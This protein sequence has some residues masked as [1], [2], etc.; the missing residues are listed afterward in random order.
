MNLRNGAKAA[1]RGFFC[2]DPKAPQSSRRP[3]NPRLRSRKRNRLTDDP[4][5]LRQRIRMMVGLPNTINTRELHL[6][7]RHITPAIREYVRQNEEIICHPTM[8]LLPLLRNYAEVKRKLKRIIAK[9][10]QGS[11]RRVRLETIEKR[12]E[13]CGAGSVCGMGFC[14]ICVTEHKLKQLDMIANAVPEDGPRPEFRSVTLL[15]QVMYGSLEEVET[16]V[17]AFKTRVRAHF[18]QGLRSHPEIYKGVRLVLAVEV[19]IVPP[20]HQ[21]MRTVYDPQR[22]YRG[23][24]ES[25]GLIGPQKKRCLVE[26][27]Y[28]PAEERPGWF[29]T[30]HGLL[31][32]ETD[33]KIE[34][35]RSRMTTLNVV[36]GN[37]LFPRHRQ[38]LFK[39]LHR[40]KIIRHNINS[41]IGYGFKNFARYANYV[42][43]DDALKKRGV[44]IEKEGFKPS[45]GRLLSDTDMENYIL[46]S[47]NL[48]LGMRTLRVFFR[49]AYKVSDQKSPDEG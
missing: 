48:G 10:G 40:K 12:V 22:D 16:A 43:S 11:P 31:L 25:S 27:G 17:R 33:A 20:F 3:T 41:V 4:E 46:L 24:W 36:N 1:A 21:V 32:A 5:K 19:D 2:P 7:P 37:S 29:I 23:E 45:Y 15:G 49:G 38:V 13:A 47:E 9:A 39:R 34:E 44:D 18:D 28:N 35:L 6:L 14:P 8:G 42:V 26:A 30:V